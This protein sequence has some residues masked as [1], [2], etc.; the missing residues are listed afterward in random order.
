MKTKGITVWERHAEKFVMA[1]AA[2]LFIGFA[3]MQFIGE[4]NAVSTSEGNI[5]PS[6]IDE[7]LEDRA[8]ELRAK[9]S[10]DADPGVELPDPVPALDQL[11]PPEAVE[12]RGGTE[13]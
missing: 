5:A 12:L 1:V 10:D 4:P 9:L 8:R 11:V 2:L 6:D 13:R 3:A 7:L